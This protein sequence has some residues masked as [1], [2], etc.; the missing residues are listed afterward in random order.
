MTQPTPRDTQPSL[1]QPKARRGVGDALDGFLKSPFSGIAP[2]A[3]LSILSAPGRFEIA[4]A[5]ALA[6]SVL[7]LLVGLARGIKI[8]LLEVFGAVFFA[9]LAIVGLFATDSVLRFLEVWAGELTNI[10]LA[11]FA[12]FTVLIR[13]PFTMAYAKDTTPQE[14]WDSP[15]FKRIN[16]VITAVWASAFTFAAAAGFFGDAVLQDAGNFWTGWILQLAAIFFAI[17]FTEFYPDYASAM[18]DLD[19]GEAAE[20]PS[21]LQMVEWLPT[22]IV[23]TGVVGLVTDSVDFLLGIGL[24]IGGSVA[25]GILAKFSGAK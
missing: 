5:S 3:L 22:F 13:R 14:Y 12:W 4:V 16:N 8:H 9:A 20:V 18:F 21:M 11:L 17:A 1:E 10:S 6:F 24:I 19:N 2:W 25:S 7:I 23:V 15:L